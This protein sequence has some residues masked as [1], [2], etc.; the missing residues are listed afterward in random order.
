MKIYLVHSNNEKKTNMIGMRKRERGNMRE[1]EGE[2]E[3]EHE[4]QGRKTRLKW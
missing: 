1:T 3:D 2:K 4:C